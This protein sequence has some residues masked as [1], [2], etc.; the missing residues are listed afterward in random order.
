MR[1]LI[2]SDLHGNLEA[3]ESLP[4]DYDQLWVLGDLV[5][6]GP[7]PAEV[8]TFVRERASIVVRGN[9]D[10][11]IAFGEDPRCS[12]RFTR[13]AK[14]TGEFTRSRLSDEDVRY[15]RDLPLKATVEWEGK[16]FLLCQCPPN[17]RF[18]GIG[19]ASNVQD[20]VCTPRVFL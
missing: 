15:L 4:K 7:N 20:R 19:S 8:I 1:I 17:R 3:V 6:Y 10:H 14:E 5:N 18:A 9:H 2:I 11:S 12:P 16:Q 13:M